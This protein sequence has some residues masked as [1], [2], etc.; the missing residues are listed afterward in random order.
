MDSRFISTLAGYARYKGGQGFTSFLLHRITG[1][2]TLIFLTVHIT[3]TSLVYIYS[4]LYTRLVAIFQ[5][6]VV[7]LAEI[8]LVF[9]VIYHGANGL[10]IAYIDLFKPSLLQERNS[11]RAMVTT[12]VIAV[13]LWL[14]AAGVMGYNMLKHGFGLFGGE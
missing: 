3:M 12:L 5:W 4:P 1:L 14:P 10:R 13:V 8:I 11:T 6:P 2:G 7:M 9:C